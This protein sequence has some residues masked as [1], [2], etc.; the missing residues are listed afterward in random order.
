MASKIEVQ[1]AAP[2]DANAQASVFSLGPSIIMKVELQDLTVRDR[3]N[4]LSSLL[5]DEDVNPGRRTMTKEAM[6]GLFKQL[7]RYCGWPK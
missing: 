6:L 4:L 5:M 3:R 2:K 7:D 1:R